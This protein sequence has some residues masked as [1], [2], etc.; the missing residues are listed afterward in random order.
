[1]LR[2]ADTVV[3]CFDGDAAGSK[4]AWRALEATL[5]RLG[6]GKQARFLFLPE[7]E[8]PD[9]L[10]RKLGEAEFRKL[11]E[12]ASTLSE[13]FFGHLGEGL[14]LASIDGRAR[15]VE[16]ALPLIGR[17]SCRERVFAVV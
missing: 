7:G 3:Y 14:D 12:G 5:P 1:M 16:L 4:A 8:D 10:V 15:L 17:A 13:F 11:I 2:A 9:S 6:E